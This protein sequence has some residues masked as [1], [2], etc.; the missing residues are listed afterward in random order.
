MLSHCQLILSISIL[1]HNRHFSTPLSEPVSG[2][3]VLS[4]VH[5]GS[6][7]K[8]EV[9]P[10]LVLSLVTLVL[11]DVKQERLR[12]LKFSITQESEFSPQC[13]IAYWLIPVTLSGSALITHR[14]KRA[15]VVAGNKSQTRFECSRAR[16]VL[17]GTR[18]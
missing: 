9:G 4:D 1:P 17:R 18:S 12:S 16:D 6:L 11:I 3:R 13:I 15:K 5:G 2:P 10:A 14:F 8:Q 7:V